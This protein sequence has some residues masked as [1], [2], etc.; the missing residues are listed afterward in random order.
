[1]TETEQTENSSLT[2]VWR[3]HDLRLT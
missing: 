1:V 3:T 2:Q